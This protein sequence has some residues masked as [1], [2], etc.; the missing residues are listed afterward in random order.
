MSWRKST[1]PSS[2]RPCASCC[3]PSTS[4]GRSLLG[5]GDEL[6]QLATEKLRLW[7][8]TQEQID[9]I[10][11]TGKASARMSIVAPLCGV[12]VRKSVV[13]GQYV[14]EGDPLFEIADLSRVWI[15]A[16]VYEDQLSLVQIGQPV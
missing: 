14:S 3:L 10:L 15:M 7:G 2:T 12:V 16:Q 11:R 1:A 9:E 5:N 8:I 4:L 6:V 13:E